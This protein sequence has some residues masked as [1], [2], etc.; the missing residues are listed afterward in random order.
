MSLS[1]LV[2]IFTQFYILGGIKPCRD[3]VNN[4]IKGSLPRSVPLATDI[5]R[6]ARLDML[7]DMPPVNKEIQ[8]K[9]SWNTEDRSLNIFVKVGGHLH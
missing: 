2:P 7:L 9:H 8:D 6:P 5:Q 1:R 4:N 3:G